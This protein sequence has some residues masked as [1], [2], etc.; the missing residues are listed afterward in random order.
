MEDWNKSIEKWRNNRE[1][2]EVCL[3]NFIYKIDKKDP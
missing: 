2:M 1:T 3:Q